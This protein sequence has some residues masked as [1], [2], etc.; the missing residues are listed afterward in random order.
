MIGRVRE[1]LDCLHDGIQK[2]REHGFACDS[3]EPQGAIYISVQ[4]LLYGKKT[5]SGM[6]L[7]NNEDVRSYLL[8]SAGFGVVPF[9]AFGVE[10]DDENGWFRASVG[11]VSVADLEQ[12]LPRLEAALTA[13]S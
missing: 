10:Q 6:V 4:F 9:A 5:P 2:L 11:A 12:C 13:L 8:Q 7:K 3:I 1:R